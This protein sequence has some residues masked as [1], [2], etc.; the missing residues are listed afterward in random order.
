[1]TWKFVE[2][3]CNGS[4]AYTGQLKEQRGGVIAEGLAILK[5]DPLTWQTIIYQSDM[6]NWP[7]NQQKYRLIARQSGYT[8]T[9]RGRGD[10]TL[11]EGTFRALPSATFS[12]SV[13]QTGPMARH[14]RTALEWK[15]PGR[16]GGLCDVEGVK[17]FGDIDPADTAQVGTASPRARTQPHTHAP[18]HLRTHPRTHP[19]T[20]ARAHKRTHTHPFTIPLMTGAIYGNFITHTHSPTHSPTQQ[21]TK[22]ARASINARAH[23]RLAA[24]RT[25]SPRVDRKLQPADSPG[26]AAWATAGSS[27]RCPPSP[28]LT[29]RCRRCS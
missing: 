11:V 9:T 14:G 7:E 20:L 23:P 15:R 13:S 3:S 21:P 29:T 27:P 17:L 1:M 22:H 16:G 28:S 19:R 5:N 8:F 18:S 25:F 26:R 10:W 6:V 12:D 2:T 4:G 24:A